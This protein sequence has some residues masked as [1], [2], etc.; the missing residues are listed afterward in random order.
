MFRLFRRPAPR[1]AAVYHDAYLVSP[2]AVERTGLFDTERPA[3]IRRALESNRRLRRCLRWLT[4]EPVAHE[5]LARIHAP[6]YLQEASQP[7]FLAHALHLP[8]LDPWDRDVW[9]GLL[10]ATGGTLLAMLEAIETRLPTANLTGGFHHAGPARAA[11]FCV[12]NDVAVGIAGLRARGFHGNIAVIDLDYHHGDG[13]EICLAE[14]NHTWCLSLHADLWHETGKPE[15]IHRRVGDDIGARDYLAALDD[16]LQELTRRM[17][18]DLVVYLAGSDPWEGDG[19]CPMRLDA[20]TLLARD[21]TVHAWARSHDS[22]FTVLPA[23]GY[24]AESWRI[25]AQFLEYLLSEESL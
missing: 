7:A 24:G 10:L 6:A 11:G 19:L 4:P 9:E 17:R 2:S 16:A 14:D 23:G 3:R 22:A 25:T 13:T 5:D 15:I 1:L 8:N 18:P 20:A 21:T 12:I